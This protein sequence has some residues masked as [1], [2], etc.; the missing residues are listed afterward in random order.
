MKNIVFIGTSLDGYIADKNNKIDW[1]NAIENPEQCDMGF[2]KHMESID[3]L[4]MGRNT[5]EMVMGFDCPWPYNKPVFVLTNTLTAL[6]NNMTDKAFIVSGGLTEVLAEIHQQGFK[7][8]YIDGGITIQNF[9]REDLIDELIIT[10]IPILLGGG[11]SLF[12]D[13]DQPMMFKH[14]KSEQFLGCIV[15]N[16]FI[17]NRT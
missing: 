14:R 8:L 15:Q 7:N 12:S 4:V 1:L 2:I 9:L 5:F 17:R 16:H 10:T 11:L 13:L 3:A 6:P